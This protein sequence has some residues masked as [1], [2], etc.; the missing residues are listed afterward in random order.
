MFEYETNEEGKRVYKGSGEAVGRPLIEIDEDLLLKLAEIQC[1]NKEIAYCLGVSID[2]LKNRF[3]DLI[4]KGRSVG[5]MRL[6]RA[7]WKNAIDNEHAV[8]QIFLSKNLLGYRDVPETQTDEENAPLPWVQ[9][10]SPETE[11]LNNGIKNETT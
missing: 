6:R 8:M 2:T 1:T 11:Q 5:N 3:S 9:S 10:T 4:D 7:M